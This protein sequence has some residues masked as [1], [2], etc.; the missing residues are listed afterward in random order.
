M[1]E[2]KKYNQNNKQEWDDF[3]DVSKNATFMLK[4]DYMDYHSD[5][6]IDYSLMFY[7]DGQ[8]I[9]LLPASLHGDE[10]RS[11]GGLT[12][13]GMITTEK[14]T[15]VK[16]LECF[17]TLKEYLLSDSIKNL[18][19]KCIPN[20]YHQY[21]ADED[22]YALFKVGAR[23]I[24][25]D[26]S[27]TIDL[28]NQIKMPKGRKAQI[29]RAKREL[30]EVHPSTNFEDFIRLENEVL[31]THHQTKAVHTAE[32]LTLLHSKFHENIK[33]YLATLKEEIIAGVLIFINKNVVHTQYMST[34][35][36]GREVGG[37]DLLIKTL[38]DKYSSTQ[39]YFDF[40]I[41]TENDGQY[42]NTGLIAQKEGFGGRAVVYD[43]YEWRIVV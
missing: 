35:S 41:S 3:V 12:Y 21:P 17:Q 13:G 31:Q 7:K 23:L 9:A 25:R 36:L 14:M 34:N 39:K 18:L 33:L 20:I 15:A 32:E 27:S 22:L 24:R 11:H 1:I 40:G 10:V 4:R 26:I 38:M 29:S 42:L 2:I 16:M 28:T 6:F 8:L 5:R 43:F 30:V 37:L 19:Y